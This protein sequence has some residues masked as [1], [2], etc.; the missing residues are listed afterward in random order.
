MVSPFLSSTCT[1]EREEGS[2][3]G[4][5]YMGWLLASRMGGLL[6]AG[7][8]AIARLHS[9]TESGRVPSLLAALASHARRQPIEFAVETV[10]VRGQG[11]RVA[12]P[13]RM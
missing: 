8:V 13:G 10:A 4:G 12:A 2:Q 6:A 11:G 3:A 1:Y 5:Y 7:R 9:L